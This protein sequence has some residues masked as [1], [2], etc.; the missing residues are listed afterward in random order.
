MRSRMNFIPRLTVAGPEFV[1]RAR[2][3]DTRVG[4]QQQRTLGMLYIT[5]TRLMLESEQA[6]R[7]HARC[8]E[9]VPQ[10]VC[11]QLLAN[12]PRYS[13]WYVGHEREMRSVANARRRDPQLMMLRNVAVEQVHRTA[14][15]DYLRLGRITGREREQ[16]LALF[17]GGGDPREA[18]LAEHRTYLL[19]A[20][21]H[22]C[23]KDLLELTGDRE[24]LD[25]VRRY[26]LAYRQ[27]FAMLC[28]R[29]LARQAGKIYVLESLLPDVKNVADRLRR[30]IIGS[31]VSA[32]EPRRVAGDDWRPASPARTLERAPAPLDLPRAGPRA[33]VLP[34]DRTAKTRTAR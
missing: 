17:H 10:R 20:S 28:D 29:S 9:E 25:L 24:G 33:A 30:V 2:E 16:T 18:A 6:V 5:S 19:A 31:N 23:T 3:D 32:M 4:G 26:E 14:V 1:T 22:V 8:G 11:S 13:E 12:E 21:T 34:A 7:N 27:Y 15:V